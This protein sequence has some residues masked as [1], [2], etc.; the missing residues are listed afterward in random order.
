VA[1]LFQAG[2]EIDAG[3][4]GTRSGAGDPDGLS[5]GIGTITRDTSVFRSGAASWKFDSGAGNNANAVTFTGYSVVDGRTYWL[6]GYFRVTAAP[7]AAATILGFTQPSSTNNSIY[8]RLRTDGAVELIVSGAAQG[9]PS[10]AITDSTWHRIELK[11]V[12]AATTIWSAAELLVDGISV[13]T[14]SGSQGRPAVGIGWGLG[15]NS[16]APGVNKTL[17]IDDVALNDSTGS[18]NNGYPGSGKVV[19]LSPLSDNARGTNWTNDAAGT[20]NL[21]DAVNN[22]P[23][24]GIADTTSSTGLHQI[25]N[26]SS[27]ANSNYDANMTSY[28]TS[29]VGA[30]DTLNAVIPW[31]ATAAPVATSA[32]AGTVGVSS[33]P[34][35]ANINLSATG[36]AGAF[37]AGAAA[38]TYGAGWK[39]SPGTMTEQPSVTLGTSPVMRITQVTSS[40][41]IAMVCGMFMYVDYTPVSTSRSPRNPAVNFNDP[42]FF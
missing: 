17:N 31:V 6:R 29:G 14:W 37:W 18:I 36:T 42:A 8:A 41:R 3:I 28:T 34:V 40:T 1:R 26:A 35:I 27:T 20:S 11:G 25:R 12:T 16:D 23:P 24:V 33:N 9:S 7:T 13:A 4:S 32:K 21:F 22:T 39:W 15:V 19:L 38:S 30:S 10:S 5:Q 2:A